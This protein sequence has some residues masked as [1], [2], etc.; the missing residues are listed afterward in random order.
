MGTK[1]IVSLTLP[2][3]ELDSTECLPDWHGDTPPTADDVI[4]EMKKSVSIPRLLQEW[5]LSGPHE[6]LVSVI[7]TTDGS[8]PTHTYAEWKEQQV[9]TEVH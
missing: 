6:V 4:R 7:T 8:R 3:V 1:V 5:D 2:E 9:L